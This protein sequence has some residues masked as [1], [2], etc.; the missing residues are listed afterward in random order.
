MSYSNAFLRFVRFYVFL[1]SFDRIAL[2]E[3]YVN[4]QT[5]KLWDLFANF[6]ANLTTSFFSTTKAFFMLYV[7]ICVINNYVLTVN[8]DLTVAVVPWPQLFVCHRYDWNRWWTVFLMSPYVF[9]PSP[10]LAPFFFFYFLFQRCFF[11][12]LLE[13]IGF[14]FLK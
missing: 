8:K 10:D 4:S 3:S 5:Q 12:W 1:W 7:F 11:F 2:L 9:T 13:L 6:I 14:I